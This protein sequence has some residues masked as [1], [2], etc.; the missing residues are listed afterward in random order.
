MTHDGLEIFGLPENGTDGI[1]GEKRW[2]DQADNILWL[3]IL[4]K[5]L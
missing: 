3:Y 4:R 5:A 2:N 1:K